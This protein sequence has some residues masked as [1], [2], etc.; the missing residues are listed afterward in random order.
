MAAIILGVLAVACLVWLALEMR[1]APT[2]W[3]DEGGFHR[4]R[5]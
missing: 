4:G 1:G 2:G 5:K 3:E